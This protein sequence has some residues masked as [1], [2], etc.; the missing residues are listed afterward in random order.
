MMRNKARGYNLK[1]CV[2]QYY[3]LEPGQP[4]NTR[5]LQQFQFTSANKED[6]TLEH[7]AG[8][9]RQKYSSGELQARLDSWSSSGYK[10]YKVIDTDYDNYAVVYSCSHFLGLGRNEFLW[11]LTRRA[12]DPGTSEWSSMTKK[13]DS[14]LTDKKFKY[15]PDSLITTS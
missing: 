12:L 11:F 14:I 4:S 5:R 13:A 1:E 10:P 3:Y 8:Q 9:L 15:Q 6:Q 7:E 2:S